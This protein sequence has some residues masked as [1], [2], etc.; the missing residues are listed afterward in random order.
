[1][2]SPCWRIAYGCIPSLYEGR[3]SRTSRIAVHISGRKSCCGSPPPAPS[4]AS[5]SL[6]PQRVNVKGSRAAIC[7][8]NQ[9]GVHRGGS[10]N[11][12]QPSACSSASGLDDADLT[13]DRSACRDASRA[14]SSQVTQSGPPP[15][16][17]W[18]P[19]YLVVDVRHSAGLDR[20][21]AAGGR[22]EQREPD[23]GVVRAALAKVGD[24]PQH[25]HDPRGHELFG[26]AR[27][28]RELGGGE[29]VAQRD[30]RGPAVALGQGGE[31]RGELLEP[32]AVAAA[33]SFYRPGAPRLSG[34]C[35]QLA[36]RFIQF[37]QLEGIGAVVD[38]L[39]CD[40]V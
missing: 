24:I 31:M 18:M 20:A 13:A 34:K 28:S 9:T 14:I 7:S 37:H 33:R 12:P 4:V 1:M 21:T 32:H 19:A 22:S 26:E 27:L 35:A 2:S 10:A 11:A 15:A 40:D 23:R 30:H 3:D 25:S 38:Q 17:T 29:A 39:A 16:P 36:R 8:T 5:H 6:S